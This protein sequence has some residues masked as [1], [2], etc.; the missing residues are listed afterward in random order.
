VLGKGRAALLGSAWTDT[1]RYLAAMAA[2]RELRFEKRLL[3]Q[4]YLRLTPHP[5]PGSIGFGYLGGTCILPWHGVAVVGPDGV[6]SCE[7]AISAVDAGYVPVW[8]ELLGPDQPWFMVPPAA[9]AGGKL[10]AD[11]LSTLRLRRR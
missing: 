5:R 6:L 8:S 11:L 2:D 9:A 4:D 1:I 7:Y 3:P 10:D